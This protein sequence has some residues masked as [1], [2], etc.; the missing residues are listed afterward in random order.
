MGEN[1]SV[2]RVPVDMLTSTERM[3]RRGVSEGSDARTASEGAT[4][5]SVD[6]E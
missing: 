6:A 4:H 3:E 1:Y 5:L 2:G